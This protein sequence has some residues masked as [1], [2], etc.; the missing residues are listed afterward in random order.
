MD[1]RRLMDEVDEGHPGSPRLAFTQ[2]MRKGTASPD[3]LLRIARGAEKAENYALMIDI[4]NTGRLFVQQ[5]LSLTI[6]AHLAESTASAVIGALD[7]GTAG[8]LALSTKFATV[9][10]LADGP[11]APRHINGRQNGLYPDPEPGVRY[12]SDTVLDQWSSLCLTRYKQHLAN[13][14]AALSVISEDRRARVFIPKF[15]TPPSLR[16]VARALWNRNMVRVS[17][18]TDVLAAGPRIPFFKHRLKLH[19]EG[20]TQW[21]LR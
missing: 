1:E 15:G 5:G 13:F 19:I 8:G 3:M 14:N 2:V 12:I 7:W 21:K 11:I 20:E 6:R 9:V 17:D 18:G 10:L 4:A 16:T